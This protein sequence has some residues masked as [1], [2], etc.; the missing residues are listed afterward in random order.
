MSDMKKKDKSALAAVLSALNRQVIKPIIHAVLDG[1]V[2][3]SVSKSIGGPTNTY[4]V[5]GTVGKDAT[6]VVSFTVYET[7]QGSSD[8]TK[9]QV[10][11]SIEAAS[12][13]TTVES[14][15]TISESAS[16]ANNKISETAQQESTTKMPMELLKER[17]NVLADRATVKEPSW[18][19]LSQSFHP[20]VDDIISHCISMKLGAPGKVMYEGCK[21]YGILVSK[22]HWP[23]TAHI[24]ADA[25]RS[26][27]QW[28]DNHPMASEQ[29]FRTFTE[30]QI[31]F[32]FERTS[33]MLDLD[34]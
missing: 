14:A 16:N 6:P 32:A 13:P 34:P 20:V 2:G 10:S 3:G 30:K 1:G 27:A 9:K 31:D 19:E 17:Q 12:T 33:R 22:F 15:S 26:I 7:T 8:D 21:V 23:R 18:Q 5:H 11:E 29:E 24:F 25:E 4:Q 28:C